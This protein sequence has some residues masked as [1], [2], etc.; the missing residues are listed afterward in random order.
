MDNGIVDIDLAA[1]CAGLRRGFRLVDHRGNAVSVKHT[2]EGKAT[3]ARTDDREGPIHPLPPSQMVVVI[4]GSEEQAG[5][6]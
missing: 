4:S 6:A 5:I 2:C 3:E 1:L